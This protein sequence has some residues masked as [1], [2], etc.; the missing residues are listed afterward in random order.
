MRK[1]WLSAIAVAIVAVGPALAGQSNARELYQRALHEETALGN[2]P[3]AMEL[4]EK[5]VAAATSD[6][7]LL[8][9]A[10]LRL[11]GVYAR[12]GR[13]EE[14]RNLLGKIVEEYEGETAYR[15]LVEVAREALAGLGGCR[16][17]G[18]R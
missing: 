13:A 15:E 16:G 7:D 3:G 5:V 11:A 18:A 14:A 12:V 2:L 17:S 10:E 4:Y 6:T 1:F 9:S 8:L